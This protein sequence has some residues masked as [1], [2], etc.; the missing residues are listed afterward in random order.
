MFHGKTHRN[1]GCSVGKSRE[2]DGRSWGKPLETLY[3]NRLVA[4][5]KT[6]GKSDRNGF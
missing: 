6:M 3:D 1:G 2:N 5:G 4:A